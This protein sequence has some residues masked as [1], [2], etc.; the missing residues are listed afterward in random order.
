MS[1]VTVLGHLRS[2]D[3][4]LVIAA[5]DGQPYIAHLGRPLGS[6]DI[7]PSVLSRGITGGGL[8]L[9]VV[10]GILAQSTLGWQGR[11]GIEVRDANNVPLKLVLSVGNVSADDQRASITMVDASGTVRVDLDI[12]IEASDTI[13]I[14]AS[15]TNTGSTP[16]HLDALGLCVPIGAEAREVL[17]L[18]GR[19]A[20]EA[21]MQRTPWGRST[22]VVENRSGR[23]SHENLG[24][25]FAGSTGF[26]ENHGQVWGVHLAWSGNFEIICDGVTENLRTITAAELLRAG[27]VAI[28]PGGTHRAPDVVIAH[29]EHG[30]NGVS[31][32]FHGRIRALHGAGIAR[33]VILNTWEAVYFDHDLDTLKRLAD[34]GA[35]VGVERFVLDDGWFH[36]R[37][38]DTAG[39]GDWWVDPAVWPN[40]LTPLVDHVTSLGMEFGLWFEPE[41]VNPDSDLYRRHPEWALDGVMTDPLL[42]R[43]QL[44]LDL[45][46][47]E[48]RN[49]LFHRIHEILSAHDIT[50]VKWDHNRPL[51]GAMSAAQTR[52]AYELFDRLTRAHANVQFESC[53]SGGGRIDHGIATWVRRFWASDSIDALDRLEIQR[54]LS[55]FMPPEVLGSHIG[56][57][58][59]HTT[60]RR[61][62]LSFRAA[63]AMFG[64]LGIEWNLL[65]LTDRERDDLESDVAVYKS[66]RHLLH[67]GDHFRT[68]HPDD[69]V[70]V[71]G[72]SSTDRAEA[73][74]AVSRLRSGPSNRTA[75][76]L[77]PGLSPDS[78]YS[79]RIIE[80]GRPRWALHRRLPDWVS[81]GATMTGAQ[82]SGLGLEIPPLLPESTILVHLVREVTK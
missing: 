2:P 1:E 24:V 33:P 77:V 41:M 61:H 66:M 27:E 57:P 74:V 51:I 47:E 50:Y 26:G 17:T 80:L 19:H 68:D 22:I 5:R 81:H 82:L 7:D 34:A 23:T 36:G 18:G 45:S 15:V 43:N 79:V 54:G 29:S 13:R 14:G 25:V 71:H 20:M 40:G 63:T 48:V 42:G 9:E 11:P 78:R 58:T 6:A 76:M 44:V 4:S 65:N 49:H 70:Q 67:G 52:G 30:L 39:L 16:L 35:A 55:T 37:R 69:T 31:R 28:E 32:K 8:D 53:A 72:V 46:R 64:W 38:N 73:L 60:G 75:P 56:S 62:A 59:C 21:V 3:T 12:V 10:P